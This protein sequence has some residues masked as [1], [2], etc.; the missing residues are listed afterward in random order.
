MSDVGVHALAQQRAKVQ[1]LESEVKQLRRALQKVVKAISAEH[2][3]YPYM[4]DYATVANALG[5]SQHRR[6]GRGV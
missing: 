2:N 3:G 1:Q 4:A 6:A 5:L